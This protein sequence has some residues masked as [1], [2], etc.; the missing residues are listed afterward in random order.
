MIKIFTPAS[1][2]NIGGSSQVPVHACNAQKVN[3]GL[4][5]QVKLECRHMTYTV[6]CDIKLNKTNK[7]KL[8]SFLTVFHK[9]S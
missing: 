4:P 5:P 9:Y 3:W 1:L 7:Q 8:F 6:K 2:R